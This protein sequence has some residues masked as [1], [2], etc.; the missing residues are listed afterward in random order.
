MPHFLL[1]FGDP[2][3]EPVGVVIIEAPSMHEARMTAVVRRFAPGV[4]VGE[5][6]ELRDRMLTSVPP[7]LIGRMT[8]G[9]EAT[10]LL[11]RLLQGS[12]PRK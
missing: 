10:Q 9:A 3:R 1:T 7:A 12:R 6:H 11:L 4:P 5:C 8:S 2:S